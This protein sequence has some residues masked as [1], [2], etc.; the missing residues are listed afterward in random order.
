M[1]HIF[2]M[3]IFII[4]N[5]I[6]LD[7]HDHLVTDLIRYINYILYTICFMSLFSNICNMKQS[8]QTIDSSIWF[9]V[10]NF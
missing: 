3:N 2:E 5:K 1:N 8:F 7:F 6:I 4:V 10:L 9:C